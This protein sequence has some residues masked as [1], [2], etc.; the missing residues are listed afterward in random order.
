MSAGTDSCK[1]CF[2]GKKFTALALTYCDY[3][4]MTGK[5]RPCP[6]G[7]GC[8]VRITANPYKPKA[9][10]VVKRPREKTPEQKEKEKQLRLEKRREQDRKRYL[11]RTEE[12]KEK[13][14]KKCREY[15]HSHKAECNAKHAEYYRKNRERI[16][17][18]NKERR[19]KQREAQR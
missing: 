9:F 10:T 6:P 2:Y 15:Y 16:N 13:D 5:R 1:G 14:R 19:R 12:D 18:Q 4:C 7:E 11:E 3:L 8:T 17:A